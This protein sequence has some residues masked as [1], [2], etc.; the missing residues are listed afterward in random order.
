MSSFVIQ[1]KFN[2]IFLSLLLF[3]SQISSQKIK[4]LKIGSPLTGR[5]EIDESHEYFKLVLPESIKGKILQ[6]TTKQNKEEEIKEDEP[7]SD[8]DV[9]VSKINK[10]PSSPR[11]A[12]WYSERYGSDVLTIP[13]ESLNP[14][15]VLYIGMYC[16]FKCRYHLNIKESTESEIILGQYNFITLQPMNKKAPSSQNTFNVIPSWSNGYVFQVKKEKKE[17]YC[18][19][20]YYHIVV[21]N[22]GEEVINSLTLYTNF[23]DK[24]FNLKPEI[25][26]YDAVERQSKKCYNFDITPA[27]K[28]EKLII[29]TN[30]FSGNIFLA[31]EGWVYKERNIQ[32]TFPFP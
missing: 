26:L 29:Q 13:T 15:D 3:I 28:K 2:L 4:D 8:P 23:P 27:Q 6:I 24:T 25:L 9:Y 31:I 19:Q 11:S 30:M 5:M 22:D 10:Y 1:T 14:N 32:F 17:Q 20:C 21:H 12:E 7:F 16:Q 18:T